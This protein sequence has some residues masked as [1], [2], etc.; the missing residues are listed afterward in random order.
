MCADV[1]IH[2]TDGHNP[3][4]HI[5]LTVRPLNE[6][7]TWQHKTEK[8]YLCV[9]DGEERGFTAAEF[10]EAQKDGWE[11]QYQYKIGKKKEYMAPSVAE[12][13]G[14]ERTS[15]YPKSTKYGRQNPIS[16]R[17]NSDEQLIIWRA[18]W[19]DEVNLCLEQ[20]GL[21][22]RIDH[23]SFADQGKDEQPTIHEG[24][25]ARAM[26]KKGIVS[27]R[28]ELNRQIK[29]DNALLRQLKAEV[30]KL[31]KAVQN[32]I[33][34]L[35]QSMEKLRANMIVFAYQV[36]YASGIVTKTR[37]DMADVVS[38]LTQYNTVTGQIKQKLAER[39]KLLLE[40]QKLSPLQLAENRRLNAKIAEL[41]EDL[42]EL[43][44]EKE[45]VI[46]SFGKADDKGMKDVKTWIDS[47]EAQIQKAEA[48]EAKYG[49]E[50]DKALV[51]YHDLEARV[52]EL[53]PEELKTARLSLRPEEEKR[54]VSKVEDA[55]GKRYDY[56]TMRE[57]KKQV[58]DLLAEERVD[59]KPWSVRRDLQQ[60]QEQ[61]RVREFNQHQPRKK[62][63][64]WER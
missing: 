43:K 57:A 16:E 32:T 8:E 20:K 63:K 39:K 15:K 4:A 36:A 24:V 60:M 49:A 6:N 29:R 2:D 3:H 21:E 61:M 59:G 30:Q 10:R 50:L 35:A 45:Q 28:C 7:G 33:P 47:R 13:Q 25:A 44:S 34:A 37:E 18:A 31:V 22:E 53:D 1:A 46:F 12:A 54:A 17:W 23:R 11:K 41:T 14:L 52:E 26:E 40:R 55:Y 19:A 58:S 9:K 27:D 62:S 51:E 64:G 38:G 5:L 42:E 48:A 56:A